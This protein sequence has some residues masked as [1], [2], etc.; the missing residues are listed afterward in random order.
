MISYEIQGVP[1]IKLVWPYL[2]SAIV[3]ACGLLVH[4]F[5]ASLFGVD[6]FSEYALSRR[7]VSLLQPVL[8]QGFA[9]ALAR[10]VAVAESTSNNKSAYS[11]LLSLIFI[12]AIISLSI[13]LI[14]FFFSP[15]LAVIF[16]GSKEYA[17]CIGPINFVLLGCILHSIA[18]SH[19]QG[20]MRIAQASVMH[21]FNL[22]L[23]PLAA[24]AIGNSPAAVLWW[25][26]CFTTIFSACAVA[27]IT[28]QERGPI[29]SLGKHAND[30]FQYAIPR[31]PGAFA[32]TALLSLPAI[33]SAHIADVRYA[34]FVAFGC[35]LLG[36]AASLIA[37]LGVVLLPHSTKMAA[38]GRIDEIKQLVPKLLGIGIGVSLLL[39]LFVEIFAKPSVTFLIDAEET[40]LVDV[41]RLMALSVIPFLI[42][43]SL[44]SL[45]DGVSAKALNSR[46][47][48]IS[49]FTLLVFIFVSYNLGGGVKFVLVGS[50]GSMCMLAAL[51]LY[52]TYR[53]LM[54][55]DL[56]NLG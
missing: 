33:I 12:F 11:Y 4:F 54:K 56:A 36:M 2:S 52:E 3:V 21:T 23:L 42:Y 45:L 35:S 50:V 38:S 34:G 48:V 28:Y 41:I 1:I 9:L 26:G 7:S 16:F 55:T 44:R 25:T 19:W 24:F 15:A 53:V 51:T 20:K 47:C 27:W 31:I 43:V 17:Y 39:V 30:L 10:Q 6:G 37:P 32:L 49:L 8:M 22:G 14:S 13:G 40:D 5:A 29:T 46:N 18:W